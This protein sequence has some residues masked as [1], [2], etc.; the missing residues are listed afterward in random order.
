MDGSLP[1]DNGRDTKGQFKDGNT[2]ASGRKGAYIPIKELLD[3]FNKLTQDRHSQTF[4]EFV[5]DKALSDNK[6][7][8]A[9]LKMMVEKQVEVIQQY[10]GGY[11]IMTPSD[12]CKDMDS[13]TV[14]KKP[15]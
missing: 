2:C 13:L 4:V 3:T 9:L 8:T 14:G 11:A 7:L 6:L 12:I 15:E 10:E 5:C 1:M